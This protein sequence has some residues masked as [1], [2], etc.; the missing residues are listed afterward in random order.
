MTDVQK[1]QWA[2]YIE[3]QK[4][5]FTQLANPGWKV[6]FKSY[7]TGRPQIPVQTTDEERRFSDA[8]KRAMGKIHM[9][10]KV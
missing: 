9:P 6:G 7:K 3:R 10:C 1:G 8:V 5:P 2:K 4:A